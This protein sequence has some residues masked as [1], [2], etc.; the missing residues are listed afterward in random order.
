LRLKEY[1]D[2]RAFRLLRL[3]LQRSVEAKLA[4]PSQDPE[5]P[6]QEGLLPRGGEGP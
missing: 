3:A 4:H 2:G 5:A 6:R 1:Y